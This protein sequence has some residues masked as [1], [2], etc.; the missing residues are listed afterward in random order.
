MSPLDQAGSMASTQDAD[1]LAHLTRDARG[2]FCELPKGYVFRSGQPL[3]KVAYL[4]RGALR[5][6][7]TDDAGKTS[8]VADAHAGD[9][10]G[11]SSLYPGTAHLTHMARALVHSELV[12]LEAASFRVSMA[13]NHTIS[14]A[15]MEQLG[16]DLK[17][18]EARVHEQVN[19]TVNERIEIALRRLALQPTAEQTPQG[20]LI[21]VSQRELGEIVGCTREMATRSIN[22]LVAA[23]TVIRKRGRNRALI[24]AR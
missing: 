22:E 5:I 18:A 8:F 1:L 6:T 23:G 21:R 13:A 4:V 14:M 11:L 17:A 20:Y 12:E 15:A 3:L 2:T 19:L 10:V 7:V 24:L 16:R 9:F